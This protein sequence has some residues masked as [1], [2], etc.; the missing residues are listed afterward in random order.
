MAENNPNDMRMLMEILNEASLKDLAKSAGNKV[1]AATGDK[2]AKGAEEAK[3]LAKYFNKNYQTWLGQSGNE[4]N[5]KTL[6]TFL[7]SKVGFTAANA[8]KIFAKSGVQD[9]TQTES[10]EETVKKADLDKIF[11]NAANFAYEYDLV[12]TDDEN[13]DDDD[14]TRRI[15]QRYKNNPQRGY[16]RSNSQSNGDPYSELRKKADKATSATEELQTAVRQNA[17]KAGLEDEHLEELLELA[18]E[19]KGSYSEIRKLKDYEDIGEMFARLG[20]AYIRSQL[21]N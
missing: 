15:R 10:L 8:R 3:R 1:K 12:Q 21:K 18:K 20:Y 17:Y 2:K 14:D 19:S 16:R 13:K 11:L 5:E 4:A 7:V 9:P 6:F